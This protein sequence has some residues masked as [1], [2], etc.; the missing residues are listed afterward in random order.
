MRKYLYS[1]III[2]N[3][4]SEYGN[5]FILFP[6]LQQGIPC[7]PQDTRPDKLLGDTGRIDHFQADQYQ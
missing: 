1:M 7:L 3:I 2:L 6:C 5:V 4:I